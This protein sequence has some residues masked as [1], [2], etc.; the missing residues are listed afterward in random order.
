LL[1]SQFCTQEFSPST[2]SLA[3][4]GYDYYDGQPALGGFF[5]IEF[6]TDWPEDELYEFDWES[7]K[8]EPD[9]FNKINYNLIT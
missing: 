6:P 7:L 3:V 1:S 5:R 2:R 9:R 4:S 8:N